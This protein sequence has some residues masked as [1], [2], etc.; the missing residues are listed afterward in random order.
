MRLAALL[1]LIHGIV[2]A[3]ASHRD[4][5]HFT[6]YGQTVAEKDKFVDK[7]HQWSQFY[8]DFEENFGKIP[9]VAGNHGT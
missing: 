6:V 3:S 2:M 8:K 9:S 7:A 5:T 1:M 4:L